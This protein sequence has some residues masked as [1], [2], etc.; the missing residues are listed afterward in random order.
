MQLTIKEESNLMTHMNENWLHENLMN[1]LILFDDQPK[2]SSSSESV[3][4][5]F[6]LFEEITKLEQFIDKKRSWYTTNQLSKLSQILDM[7]PNRQQTIRAALK[8]PKSTFNKLLKEIKTPR[9]NLTTPKWRYGAKDL[10]DS[11]K[12][13]Y[14]QKLIHP[15]CKPLSI[16]KI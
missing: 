2:S 7:Y 3:S 9:D 14:I 4:P 10:L 5:E 13:K 15:P 11:E 12:K 1:D 16:W 6:R 8:I